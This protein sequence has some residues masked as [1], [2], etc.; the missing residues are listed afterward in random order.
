MF[1]PRSAVPQVLEHN[2]SKQDILALIGLFF[3]VFS[4]FAA[5]IVAWPVFKRWPGRSDECMCSCDSSW[6]EV[7]LQG[8]ADL[9]PDRNVRVRRDSKQIMREKYEEWLRFQEWVEVTDG[10][11]YP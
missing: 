7:R 1:I 6:A 3:A 9:F 2:W 8:N 11:K 4:L 10:R 5:I